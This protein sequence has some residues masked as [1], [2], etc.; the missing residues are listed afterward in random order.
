[1]KILTV[2]FMHY[3]VIVSVWSQSHIQNQLQRWSVHFVVYYVVVITTFPLYP[4]F[5]AMDKS[6]PVALI[7]T[8]YPLVMFKLGRCTN[9]RAP[10]TSVHSL[11]SFS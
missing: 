2:A 11:S 9:L 7:A 6:L 8:L 1:M 10:Q 3:N 4:C 5:I